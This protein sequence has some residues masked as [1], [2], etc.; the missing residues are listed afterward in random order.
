[1][2]LEI[3]TSASISVTKNGISVAG[4]KNVTRDMA[5][6]E[7]L[8]ATQT[9]TTATSQ[10]TVGG[11]DDIKNIFIQNLSDTESVDIGLNTPLTQKCSTLLPGG[12]ILLE[13]PPLA[14]Y[15]KTVANTAD[16]WV[17]VTES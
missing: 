7:M 1:M 6:S 4:S 16:I 10:I 8:A 12:F 9:L 17:V 13:Q 5:G 15:A 14:L 3:S 2:S 11:C